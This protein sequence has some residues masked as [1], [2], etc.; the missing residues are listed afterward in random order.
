M[1]W[2]TREVP[3]DFSVEAWGEA[4]DVLIEHNEG[5]ES[6]HFKVLPEGLSE[7]KESD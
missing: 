2:E 1:D 5:I 4:G 6:D 7:S 3:K